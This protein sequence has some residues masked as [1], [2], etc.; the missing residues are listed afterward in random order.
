LLLGL[1]VAAGLAAAAPARAA[2]PVPWYSAAPREVRFYPSIYF[3]G[4]EQLGQSWRTEGIVVTPDT[5]A[6]YIVEL[7]RFLTAATAILALFMVTYGGLLWLLAG[8]NQGTISHAKEVVTG[9]VAGMLVAL[10]SYALLASIS[11]GL[12]QFRSLDTTV[13][14]SAASPSTPSGAAGAQD[15]TQPNWL[16]A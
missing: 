14:Q 16:K 4:L 8:G 15:C 5:L 13:P 10:L 9:A 1:I 7:Y 12:V 6:R 3:P 2:D 11:R